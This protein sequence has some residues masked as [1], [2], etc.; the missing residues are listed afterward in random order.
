M[1]GYEAGQDIG[2]KKA[3]V[4]RVSKSARSPFITSFPK[5]F[6]VGITSSEATAKKRCHRESMSAGLVTMGSIGCLMR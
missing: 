2:P 6:T 3:C 5:S 4:R 1:S